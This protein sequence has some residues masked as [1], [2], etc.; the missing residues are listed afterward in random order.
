VV[1]RIMVVN[2]P[3]NVYDAYN[4][5]AEKLAA[6]APEL[7]IVAILGHY[8][9]EMTERALRF[10]ALGGLALLNAS[11]T[12]NSLSNLPSGEQQSFFRLTTP[13]CINA[14]VL[15]D[16]LAKRGSRQDV[17]DRPQRVVLV[18][19]KNSQYCLSYQAT[20]RSYLADHTDQFTLLAAYDRLG[21]RPQ[22]VY[23][24]MNAIA[25]QD[26]DVIV[27]IPDGGI[28]PNS[29][30]NVGLISRFNFKTGL[31]AGSATLYQQNVLHWMD[32]RFYPAVSDR[33]MLATNS[34]IAVCI[35]WHWHSPINGCQG[36]NSLGQQFCAVG[37]VL[38]GSTELTWRSATA[39]DALLVVLEVLR[40][41]RCTTGEDVL[42][43]LHQHFKVQRKSLSGVTG[44]IQ[45]DDRGDRLN[46]PA[47]IVTVVF[48]AEQQQWCWVQ[49]E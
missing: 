40:R 18:Y 4:Q 35:P 31:I 22:Q 20:I 21:D 48:D 25:R 42:I 19:N 41:H 28:E 49:A 1:L 11:S 13:D 8:S 9:S 2:D 16:Y 47:E 37:Q 10:Y 39:F 3:N 27:V 6:I 29:L 7:N 26:A 15:M 34:Q 33:S 44:L 46:P 32:E 43:H 14:V 36:E 24:T 30:H 17:S 23:L 38:W 5:T 45:F 12:S